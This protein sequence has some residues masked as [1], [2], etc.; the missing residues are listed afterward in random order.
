[1]SFHRENV[2][3]QSTDGTWNLGFF[4]VIPGIND[5]DPDYDPEWDDEVDFGSFEWVTRN[6]PTVDAARAAWPG[7]NPGGTSIISHTPN[8]AD[9]CDRYDRMA[10]ALD[11]ER[12]TRR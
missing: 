7:A 8:N 10:D 11:A 12:A 2:T 3:W 6:H 9:V 5:D 1:M 4:T